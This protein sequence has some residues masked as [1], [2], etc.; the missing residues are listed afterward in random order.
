MGHPSPGET[1]DY[2]VFQKRSQE[3]P[4]VVTQP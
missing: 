4:Q 2:E 3:V 1:G